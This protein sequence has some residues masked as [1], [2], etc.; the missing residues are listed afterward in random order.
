MKIQAK[1]YPGT[2]KPE[3]VVKGDDGVYVVYTKA[4]AVD[5][6]A[7]AAAVKLIA[8]YFGVPQSHMLLI[9]GATSRHKVFEITLQQL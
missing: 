3:G 1:I 6:K 5:G 9:H 8:K 7:N 4:R 2:R